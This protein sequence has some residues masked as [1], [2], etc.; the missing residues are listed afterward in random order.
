MVNDLKYYNG[1]VA[2]I[3]RIPEELKQLYATAFEIDPTW[4]VEAGFTPSKMD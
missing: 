1:S 4:L 2:K 3:N